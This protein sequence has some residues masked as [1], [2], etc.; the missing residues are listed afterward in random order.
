MKLLTS[1]EGVAIELE[2]GHSWDGRMLRKP[3]P[4]S[5]LNGVT[6]QFYNDSCQDYVL[7]EVREDIAHKRTLV[8]DLDE[9]LVHTKFDVVFH[10]CF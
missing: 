8:L 1:T 6:F 4:T 10:F 9:T 7:P 2:K 3:C 5:H